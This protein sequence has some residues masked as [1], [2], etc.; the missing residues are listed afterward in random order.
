VRIEAHVL[1]NL[2]VRQAVGSRRAACARVLVDPAPTDLQQCRDF[3]DGE[4][5]EELRVGVDALLLSLAC[6]S[7][8]TLVDRAARICHVDHTVTCITL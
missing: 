4:E 5:L 3:V 8:A 2:D 7:P 1:A 6:A